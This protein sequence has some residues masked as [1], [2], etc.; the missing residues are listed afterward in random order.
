[1]LRPGY[2]GCLIG[3]ML[4]LVPTAMN[5]RQQSGARSPSGTGEPPA[6]AVIFSL[7]CRVVDWDSSRSRPVLTLL[8]PPE[9]ARDRSCYKLGWA[10]TSK[11]SVDPARVTPPA[12]KITTARFRPKAIEVWLS[13][14]EDRSSKPTESWVSFDRVLSFQALSITSKEWPSWDPIAETVCRGAPTQATTKPP[15]RD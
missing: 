15:Q 8:C 11:P 13:L 4:L 10:E 9:S 2:F 5:D 6:G 12:N 3:T 14:A 1:M 7:T